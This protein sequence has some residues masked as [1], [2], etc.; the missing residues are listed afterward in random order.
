MNLIYN[1]K[2]HRN[3]NYSNFL[4]YKI[5]GSSRKILYQSHILKLLQNKVKNKIILN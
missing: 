4:L 3:I 2:F 5:R 1:I